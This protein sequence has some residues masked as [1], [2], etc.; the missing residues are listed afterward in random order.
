MSYV[1]HTLLLRNG[2]RHNWLMSMQITQLQPRFSN[3]TKKNTQISNAD[4]TDR[5]KYSITNLTLHRMTKRDK[6]FHSF[7]C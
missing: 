5:L 1:F 3:Q 6:T 2:L 7:W 4:K